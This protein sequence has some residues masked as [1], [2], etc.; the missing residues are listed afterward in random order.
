MRLIDDLRDYILWL[1][2]DAE[3][4]NQPI[5]DDIA[6]HLLSMID[7]EESG[8]YDDEQPSDLQEHEDFA[9]DNDSSCEE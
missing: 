4:L 5:L 9:H 6:D 7:A 3:V 8:W 2:A 1:R